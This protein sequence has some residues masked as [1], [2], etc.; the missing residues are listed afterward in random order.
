VKSHLNRVF[1]KLGI[2]N[3]RQLAAEAHRHE[4]L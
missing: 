1:A 3:R 2:S 4:T